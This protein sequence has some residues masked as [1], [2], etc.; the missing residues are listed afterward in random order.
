MIIGVPWET[1]GDETRV[2]LVPSVAEDLIE[3]GHEV[4]VAAGAG[5]GSDWSDADYREVGCEIVDDRETVFER[6]DIVV[7]VRALGATPATSTPTRRGR[8][9]SVSS[10]P[11]NLMR[12]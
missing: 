4:C 2:A 8:S 6:A 10:A 5:E 3:D 11:M 7:Q 12:S 9:S 1:A